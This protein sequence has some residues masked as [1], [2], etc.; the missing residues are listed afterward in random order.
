MAKRQKIK[1]KKFSFFLVYLLFLK[2]QLIYNGL[3]ISALQQSDSVIHIYMYIYSHSFSHIILYLVPSQ[4]I[5]YSSLCY[6]VGPH[7]LSTPSLYIFKH[8]LFFFFG[9]QR[10]MEFSRQGSDQSCCCNSHHRCGNARSF[11]SLWDQTL[12]RHCGSH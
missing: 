6:T 8:I 9:C 2:L 4:G 5:R 12:Q 3:S 11:N 10:H 1:K 7:C